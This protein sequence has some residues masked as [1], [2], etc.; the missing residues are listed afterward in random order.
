MKGPMQMK[1]NRLKQ[2][3]KDLTRNRDLSFLMKG[4]EHPG[5]SEEAVKTAYEEK[6][7]KEEDCDGG[8]KGSELSSEESISETE[9]K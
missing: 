3:V 1:N 2:K 8:D 5:E 9:E 6:F 4:W 7:N